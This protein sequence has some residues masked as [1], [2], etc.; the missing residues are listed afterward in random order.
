MGN[1]VNYNQHGRIGHIAKCSA[2][3]PRKVGES[4]STMAS[5]TSLNPSQNQLVGITTPASKVDKPTISVHNQT[6]TDTVLT[7]GDTDA[8]TNGIESK[9]NDQEFIT[10]TSPRGRE[11]LPQVEEKKPLERRKQ[12]LRLK[13]FCLEDDEE[14]GVQIS[15]L[16]QLHNY[17]PHQV[18]CTAPTNNPDLRNLVPYL[19]PSLSASTILKRRTGSMKTDEQ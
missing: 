11:N 6:N 13:A 5:V 1:A 16:A 4:Y 9:V 14:N 18:C 19:Q 2:N 7:E 12:L 8:S 15:S 3:Q 17:K 10:Q